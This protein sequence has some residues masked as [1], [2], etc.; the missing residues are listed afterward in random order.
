MRMEREPLT[1]EQLTAMHDR[2]MKL[3]NLTA[4]DVNVLTE[5]PEELL[6]SWRDVIALVAEVRR[7]RAGPIS[8]PDSTA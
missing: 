4:H 2:A 3:L 5:A 1:D 7:L 6:Q 8:R